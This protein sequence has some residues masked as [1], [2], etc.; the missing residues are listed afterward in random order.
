MD[1]DDE[2]AAYEALQNAGDKDRDELQEEL[3]EKFRQEKPNQDPDIIAARA[4]LALDAA[5]KY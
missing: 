4:E 2:R 5:E 1:D 3:E